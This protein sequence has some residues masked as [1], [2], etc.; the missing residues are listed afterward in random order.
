MQNP[1]TVVQA[2]PPANTVAQ[3]NIVAPA[4]TVAPEMPPAN[5]VALPRPANPSEIWIRTR[6]FYKL[7]YKK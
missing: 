1:S 6:E 5:T 2:I 4:N 7:N 3:A